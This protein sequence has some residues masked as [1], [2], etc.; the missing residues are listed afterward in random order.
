MNPPAARRLVTEKQ[1][2]ITVFRLLP[3]RIKRYL[4]TFYILQRESIRNS[5]KGQKLYE[6]STE[7]HEYINITS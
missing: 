1:S 6:E 2:G 3:L 4:L 7:T 5:S